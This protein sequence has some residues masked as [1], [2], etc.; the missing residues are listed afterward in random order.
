MLFLV[1]SDGASLDSRVAKRFGHARH[2]LLVESKSWIIEVLEGEPEALPK[3]GLE[4]AA[5]RGIDGV[6]TGNL[7]PHA[8]ED[9]LSLGLTGYLARRRTVQDAIEEVMAGEIA[10]MEGPT[11]KRSIHSHRHSHGAHSEEHS[12]GHNRHGRGHGGQH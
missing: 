2:H 9:F 3:H 12:R 7:G 10:P 8:W 4:R 6:I 1:A 5:A 11:M